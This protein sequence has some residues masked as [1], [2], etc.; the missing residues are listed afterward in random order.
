MAVDTLIGAVPDNW[1]ILR[2]DECCHVQ[3]GPSG[4]TLRSSEQ[5]TKGTPVVKA[6]DLGLDRISLQSGV[7]VSAETAKRLTRYKLQPG[8]ILLARIGATPRH[9][10]VAEQQDGWLLG[11]SCIRVR[12]L[13]HT[14]PE[15]LECYLSHPAVQEW[16]VE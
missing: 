8:D 16:L 15:Y 7:C 10:I 11:G 4:T 12:V 6:T 9:A 5:V 3:P 2:L 1:R 13:Q 14:S